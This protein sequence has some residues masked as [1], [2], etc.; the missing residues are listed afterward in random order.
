M[1]RHVCG[2]TPFRVRLDNL[3]NVQPGKQTL[4]AV[5]ADPDNG[6]AGGVD[7]AH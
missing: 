7:H 3:T 6:D 4:V 2:Y 1:A 5:Y